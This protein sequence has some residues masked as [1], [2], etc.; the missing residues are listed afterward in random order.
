M[1]SSIF[2]NKRW[3]VGCLFMCTFLFLSW[4]DSWN[5]EGSLWRNVWG[6]HAGFALYSETTLAEEFLP[7]SPS[8]P[9]DRVNFRWEDDDNWLKVLPRT[10]AER[11]FRLYVQRRGHPGKR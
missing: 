4:T 9:Q 1:K 8:I 5:P 11:Y 7:V 6:I 10:L 3:C 2:A